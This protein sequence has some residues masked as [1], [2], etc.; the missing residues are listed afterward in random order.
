MSIHGA[1]ALEN[2]T[3]PVKNPEIVIIWYIPSPQ[4]GLM[5]ADALEV[6]FFSLKEGRAAKSLDM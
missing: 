5:S 6:D 4:N 1:G 2:T 3:F